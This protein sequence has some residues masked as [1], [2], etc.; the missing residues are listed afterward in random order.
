MQICFF[1][2]YYFK[3]NLHV[4]WFKDFQTKIDFM[5]NLFTQ[6]MLSVGIDDA[7]SLGDKPTN[8]DNYVN[9]IRNRFFTGAP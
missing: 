9:Q 5:T 3:N 7:K 4:D 1:T 6:H 2:K 8:T